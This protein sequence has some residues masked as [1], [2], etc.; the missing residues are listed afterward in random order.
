MWRHGES[1]EQIPLP[2]DDDGGEK[3]PQL[4]ALAIDEAR[5]GSDA[6]DDDGDDDDGA[7]RAAEALGS[8]YSP[9]PAGDEDVTVA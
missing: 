1:R 6:D 2:Y 7:G 9:T 3:Q 8:C 5:E 4:G